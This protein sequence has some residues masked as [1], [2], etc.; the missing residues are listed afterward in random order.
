ML[1][2]DSVKYLGITLDSKI[3]L[4]KHCSILA[5]KLSRSV[6]ILSKLRHL[7]LPTT[8]HNLYYSMVRSHL[9]YGITIWENTTDKN[10]KRLISLQNKAIKII[11]QGKR[12]DH[13]T[14]LYH[15]LQISKLKDLYTHEIAKMMHKYSCKNLPQ[16]LNSHFTPVS[17]IHSRSTRLSSSNLNLY[18][19]IHK[20][21]RLQKNLKFMGPKIWNAIPHELKVLPFNKLKINYKKYLL[22]KYS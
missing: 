2:K 5:S 11:A 9:L 1:T 6:G 15:K 8:L 10:L 7:L 16:R 22:S 20:T 19:P 21:Q 18:L 14:P 13:I 12:W 4:D 3:N 17:A